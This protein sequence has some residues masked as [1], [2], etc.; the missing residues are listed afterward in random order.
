MVMHRI[1]FGVLLVLSTLGVVP[2]CD[3]GGAGAGSPSPGVGEHQEKQIT[4]ATGGTVSATG[5]ALAIPP[6]ALSADTT[7]TVDIKSKSDYADSGSIAVNVFEF[8]PTGTQFALPVPLTLDLYDAT[9]PNGKVA[10]VAYFDGSAWQVLP[11]SVVSGGKISATTT[12]FTAFTVV[13]D[14]GEQT[15]DACGDGEFTPCGGD[16][17]GTWSFTGACVD[18]SQADVDPTNGQ[19]PE[20]VLTVTLD[21][22]G[23]LTFNADKTYTIDTTEFATH[24]KTLPASCADAFGG[25]AGCADDFDGTMDGNGACVYTKV[26]KPGSKKKSGSYTTTG[27]SFTTT[28]TG[29]SPDSPIT[30]CVTGNTLKAMVT[31]SNGAITYSAARQ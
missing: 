31:A 16:I 28:E 11:D 30:Y 13:W 26:D 14:N 24:I 29:G 19:C 25:S 7:I 9:A 5:V 3:D 20:T 15:G 23:T 21:A 8:G 12:H 22:T 6:G 10:K 1:L 2:G 27:T 17:T 18:A 4:A